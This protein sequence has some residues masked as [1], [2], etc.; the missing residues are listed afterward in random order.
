MDPRAGGPQTW[1]A[2]DSDSPD[3]RQPESGV[4]QPAS[5][6]EK[7]KGEGG[8]VL[9]VGQG[10]ESLCGVWE[11]KDAALDATAETFTKSGQLLRTLVG[12][13]PPALSLPVPLPVCGCVPISV[14]VPDW[15]ERRAGAGAGGGHGQQ[16]AGETL[17]GDLHTWHA[18]GPPS[19]G[20]CKPVRNLLCPL[21]A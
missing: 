5:A 20:Q 3:L 8:G 14:S 18:R 21:L 4:R 13:V 7:G 2:W 11:Q 19:S 1:T 17:P 9:S 12:K 10:A 6:K 15:R 16:S